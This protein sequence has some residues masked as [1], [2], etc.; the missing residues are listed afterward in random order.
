MGRTGR[1]TIVAVILLI[2]AAV[3]GKVLLT[4]VWLQPPRSMAEEGRQIRGRWE[5]GWPVTFQNDEVPISLR[6][7]FGVPAA[8]QWDIEAV[9]VL[10]LLLNVV[11]ALIVGA[12]IAV[13]LL[14]RLSR[15]RPWT[16]SLRGL[17]VVTALI[18][19]VLGWWLR[20]Q[21]LWQREQAS[22]LR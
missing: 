19:A 3:W 21:H 10:N 5:R 2:L 17:L 11:L 16:F 18:A 15:P 22:H 1:Y 14:R 13:W 4:A 20:E 12:L 8:P 9:S 6:S 7:A